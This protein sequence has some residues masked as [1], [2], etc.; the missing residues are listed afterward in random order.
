MNDDVNNPAERTLEGWKE[1]ATFL[2]RDART[3]TRWEK[4]EGLPVRRHLHNA[5]SSVY[6]LPSELNAWLAARAPQPAIPPS[7]AWWRPQSAFGLAC[8]VL[9]LLISYKGGPLAALQAQAQSHP[10]PTLTEVFIGADAVPE[11]SFS[12]DGKLYAGSDYYNSGDLAVW[13]TDTGKKTLLT[14]AKWKAY[15]AAPIWSP[16]GKRI[17]YGWCPNTRP[18]RCEIRAIDARGGEP[19]VLFHSDQ[20]SFEDATDWSQGGKF[21]LANVAH[22]NGTVSLAKLSLADHSVAEL[23]NLAS[24]TAARL[25]PDGRFVAYVTQEAGKRHAFV[26]SFGD[27]TV[28]RVDHGDSQIFGATW[29]RDGGYLLF[30]S[31]RSGHNDL[32]AV[33]MREGK[34]DGEPRDIYP[35][36]GLAGDLQWRDSRT[37]W[38]S[39]HTSSGQFYS[40]ALNRDGTAA[41]GEPQSPIPF[42]AG[43]HDAVKWSPDGNRLALIAS[44]EPKMKLYVYTPA[45]RQLQLYDTETF[46][47]FFLAG[48]PEGNDGP[49]VVAV[50]DDGLTG[51]YRVLASA[52]PQ[53]IYS[54]PDITFTGS[55]ISLDGRTI[56]GYTSKAGIPASG[57][58]KIVR[59]MLLFDL[60]QRKV[61][62]DPD[63]PAT[64]AVWE[65]NFRSVVYV[66]TKSG[67]PLDSVSKVLYGRVPMRL[68]QKSLLSGETKPF[69]ELPAGAIHTLS[70]APDANRIALAF[71]PGSAAPNGTAWKSR[72][73]VVNAGGTPQEIQIPSTH[74]PRRLVWSPDGRQLGYITDEHK[75]QFYML[76]NF[77]PED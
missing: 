14:D 76:T 26:L 47:A 43:Q 8:A 72:L 32:W 53:L 55:R 34:V 36:F 75:D 73:F 46:R 19:E 66:M 41:E 13:D 58:G 25:S 40:V 6:A 2:K 39:K 4:S 50:A 7:V 45:T 28:S 74:N 11:G 48:W 29:S 37:L 57:P 17:V 52:K 60:K 22:A 64:Q 15:P 61:L 54:S 21:L 1:I 56:V 49:V 51:F 35:D 70:M 67:E 12:P 9:L 42:L 10:A 16:D 31:D 59:R 63:V 30:T 71:E 5:R 18:R 62:P 68:F 77:L 24:G 65:K 23:R 38:F 33:P 20:D 44:S 69:A 3:V 27:N